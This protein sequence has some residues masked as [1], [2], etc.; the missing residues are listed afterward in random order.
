MNGM[1]RLRRALLGAGLWV[2][3][4]LPLLAQAQTALTVQRPD[5]KTAE[6]TAAQLAALPHAS[7]SASARDKNFRFDGIDVLELLRAAGVELTMPLHGPA[8]RRVL[9]VH[10]ADG[11]IA[12]FAL[13]EFDA[14]LGARKAY[15]VDRQDGAALD[16]K[17]GP[18]RIVVP[19]EGRPTRW[20]RQV[21]KLVV[22]DLR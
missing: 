22:S 5:G 21:T 6:F 11:Y 2:G 8:L 10:A 1:R 20:V 17:E 7:F 3:L 13:A 19:G 18:L 16:A 9:A 12:A 4:V 14:T 15:L